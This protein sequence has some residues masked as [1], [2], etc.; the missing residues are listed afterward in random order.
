MCDHFINVDVFEFDTRELNINEKRVF[1]YKN[2]S[3]EVTTIFYGRLSAYG[4]ERS[5]S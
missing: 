2:I 5:V 3:N 1:I 4:S